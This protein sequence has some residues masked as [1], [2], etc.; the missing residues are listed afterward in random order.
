MVRKAGLVVGWV[1]G[2]DGAGDAGW[3]HVKHGHRASRKCS[4]PLTPQL[5][6]IPSPHNPLTITGRRAS[7]LVS[8]VTSCFSGS[9]VRQWPAHFPATPLAVTPM[10][11]ARAVLYPSDQILRD[12]LSWRQADTHV[13]NLVRCRRGVECW[14]KL[15]GS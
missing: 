3:H 4:D 9:Y 11:D 6:A 10:F 5:I 2:V 7:K 1:G 13:N 15:D 8:L 12:Y 14:A